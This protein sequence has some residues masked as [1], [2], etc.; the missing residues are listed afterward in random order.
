MIVNQLK[1]VALLGVLTAILLLIGGY[2]GGQ[3]GLTIAFGFAILMNV[4]SY[5]W[6]HKL[7]LAMYKA[8]ELPQ[9]QA[10][11]IHKIVQE[12]AKDANIP[13]PKIY[14]VHT[15]HSNA[16]ATGPNPKKAVVA[17]TDGIV[18]LLTKEELKGVLAHEISHV[19]NRDILV[20]TIAAT[21]ASVISYIAFMARWAAIF[22]G[23][24]GD[25][26]SGN[27][28]E[29]LLLAIV[30]PLAAMIVQLAISRSREY[31]ADERGAKLIG[32]GKP[33]ASA[34]AKLETASKQL[35]LGKGAASTGHLFIIKPFR[36]AGMMNLFSTH[37]PHHKRIERLNNMKF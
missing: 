22:G 25:N 36:G 17:V 3:Q 32:N 18:K 23:M 19:K 28:L 20:S 33:L 24:R 7:V 1:T 14:I 27:I 16:F 9:S 10:P 6:S 8:K 30:A 26:D 15:P 37:P 11:G 34:L 4:G 35:P 29:L 31:L 12:I 13:K 2:F 5:F 21:I